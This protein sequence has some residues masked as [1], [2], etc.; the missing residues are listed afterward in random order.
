MDGPAGLSA[1]F[2]LKYIFTE[3][4]MIIKKALLRRVFNLGNYETLHVEVEA[5]V[6][7]GE[8]V[9]T[10]LQALDREA[11]QFGTLKRGKK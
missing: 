3:A 6:G 11:V 2:T 10:V 9:Q 8:N 5:V 4:K 7:E 1:E